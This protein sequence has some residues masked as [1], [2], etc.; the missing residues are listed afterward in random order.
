MMDRLR[1]NGSIDDSKNNNN[2]SKLCAKKKKNR[3]AFKKRTCVVA[4]HR[5]KTRTVAFRVHKER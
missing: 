3:V 5:R 1:S 2:Y 4:L